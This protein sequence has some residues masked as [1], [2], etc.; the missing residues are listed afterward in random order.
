M[1]A[2]LHWQ[3]S[4]WH[5]ILPI[6]LLF[7]LSASLVIDF[8]VM[9][10]MYTSGMMAESHFVLAGQALFSAFNRIEL[11][12][13]ATVCVGF[14]IK[15][16]TPEIER[17]SVFRNLPI[18]VVLLTIALLYTYFVTPTMSGLGFME[19][20][21]GIIPNQMNTL[22]TLYWLLESVKIFSLSLLFSRDFRLFH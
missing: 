11:I 20:S 1:K 10:V 6:A 4:P 16:Q 17:E 5:R 3:D 21:T 22:H 12:L 8:L 9:P 13:A 7:W 2:P 15:Q 18:A 19:E 14:W